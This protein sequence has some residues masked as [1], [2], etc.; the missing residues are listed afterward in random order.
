MDSVW[1]TAC[2][3]ENFLH[4]PR[5]I[6]KGNLINCDFFYV[7]FQ[8]NCILFQIW[9]LKWTNWTCATLLSLTE[10]IVNT[11]LKK[12]Q[13]YGTC[14]SGFAFKRRNKLN[15]AKFWAITLALYFLFVG[16]LQVIQEVFKSK[17]DVLSS[18]VCIHSLLSGLFKRLNVQ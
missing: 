7:C 14:S 17:R 16:Q 13:N 6:A 2:H 9:L 15:F 1:Y 5:I 18:S 8:N 12:R 3:V 10:K 4:H 11:T